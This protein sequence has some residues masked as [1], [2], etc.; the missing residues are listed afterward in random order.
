[1]RRKIS[2]SILVG[3]IG[4]AGCNGP[5][6]H[7][8][9]AEPVDA[10]EVVTVSVE[11]YDAAVGE[12]TVEEACSELCAEVPVD[13]ITSCSLYQEIEDAYEVEC[14]YMQQIWCD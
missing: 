3:M 12:G 14:H 5:L 10:S 4:I 6:F 8:C 7:R 1:M 2:K 11:D 9:D 13:E